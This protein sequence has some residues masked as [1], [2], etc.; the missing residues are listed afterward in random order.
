MFSTKNIKEVSIICFK[1]HTNRVVN[2][3]IN[4]CEFQFKSVAENELINHC[5][6]NNETVNKINNLIERLNKIINEVKKE[7]IIKQVTLKKQSLNDLEKEVIKLENK[8]NNASVKRKA[9]IINELLKNEL[10]INMLYNKFG[11]QDGI[12]LIQG[13]IPSKKEKQFINKISKISKKILIEVKEPTSGPIILS[14]KFPFKPFELLTKFYSAPEYGSIDPTPIFAITFTICFGLMFSDVIDGLIISI[15]S[16]IGYLTKKHEFFKIG[17][18]LGLSVIF[19]GFMFGEA[20]G[21]LIKLKPIWFDPFNN[22]L[23]LLFIALTFGSIHIIIGHTIGL[24]NDIKKK[25]TFKGLS[26]HLSFIIMIIG[27]ALLLIKM[28]LTG[29][30]I[31]ITGVSLLMIG[32]DAK[33]IVELPSII[34]NLISYSRIL[35]IN[36]AHAGIARAFE[37]LSL[38]FNNLL[39]SILIIS[40]G[41][42]IILT[43]DLVVAFIH[44]LRLHFVEFF[45]KFMGNGDWFTPYKSKKLYTIK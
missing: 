36:M 5:V 42:L 45:T 18:I 24:I 14:N 13:W 12:R 38:S 26:N 41:Q 43:L 39:L 10:S 31:I 28:Q 32:R 7:I 17:F 25:K 11:E 2:T 23:Q 33:S 44:S 34:G 1:E 35:A 29:A 27:T 4:E 9:L 21:G 15:A 3:L 6:I 22:P 16:I 8:K 19:F 40:F 37:T 20:M 30:I